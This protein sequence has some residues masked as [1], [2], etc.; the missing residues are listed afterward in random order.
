MAV[1]PVSRLGH[2]QAAV[3]V[4]P[5]IREKRRREKEKELRRRERGR[6]EKELRRRERGR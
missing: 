1:L 4:S 5:S 2:S 6:K 3:T